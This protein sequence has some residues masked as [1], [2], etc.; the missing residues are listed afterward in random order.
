MAEPLQAHAQDLADSLNGNGHRTPW[1]AAT[2]IDEPGRNHSATGLQ[3][4]G[5]ENGAMYTVHATK[6][7][8]DRVKWPAKLPVIEPST[9]LGN[10]YG[11]VLFWRPQLVLLVNERTLFPVLMPL[12]PASTLID[13]F[14]EFLCHT[15]EAHGVTSEFIQAETSAM[16]EGRYAKTANRSVVGIMNEFSYLAEASRAHRGTTD[17]V[18]LA[19]LL[20]QTPFRS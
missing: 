17:P 16:S 12:A 7:L 8:L 15:L 10:W 4:H 5:R 11:T 20:S 3:L 13:R 6:K 2:A 9:E 14:P 19:I 18:T 1:I